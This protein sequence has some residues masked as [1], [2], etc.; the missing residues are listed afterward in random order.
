MIFKSNAYAAG[1]EGKVSQEFSDHHECALGHWYENGDGRAEFSATVAYGK[2]LEPHRQVH[3]EVNKAMTLLKEDQLR[4]TKA[5][6]DCFEAAEKASA[7][8]FDILNDMM[9][10]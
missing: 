9:E 10:Q 3:A 2:L 6:T 7:E 8:L 5:I 4:N 1:F